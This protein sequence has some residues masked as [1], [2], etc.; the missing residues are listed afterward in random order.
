MLLLGKYFQLINNTKQGHKFKLFTI[1]VL[2]NLLLIFSLNFGIEIKYKLLDLF[3]SNDGYMSFEG[4]NF[5]FFV[6]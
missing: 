6:L 3:F 4:I 5:Q 1:L 2:S